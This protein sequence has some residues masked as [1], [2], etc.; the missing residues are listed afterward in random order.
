MNVNSSKRFGR[1][2]LAFLILGLVTLSFSVT[3]EP[4]PPPQSA[5]PIMVPNPATD[6]WRAVRQR[7]G[8]AFGNTQVKGVE[9][10]VL[11]DRTGED[12]RNFRRD[13][14]IGQAGIGI[15][16]VAGLIFL[17]YLKH[18]S[19]KIENGRSGRRIKRFSEYDRIVHWFSAILFVF[20]A[21]TGLILLFG[22]F[23]VLPVF[24]PEVFSVIASACK[25]GHNL[26]GPVYLLSIILLFA[27]Y[28]R[29]NMFEK[30]DARWLAS[31]GGLIGNHHV[32]AGFFNAG[33]KIWFWSAIALGVVV[34]LTGLVLIFP[35]IGFS[36]ELMQLALIVH[37]ITAV[38]FI[39]GSFGH[40]YIGTVGSEGSIDS[41]TT[42]YVDV[43]W[44]T[45]H[46]D[47]WYQEVKHEAVPADPSEPKA[48]S[49]ERMPADRDMQPSPD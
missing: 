4:P 15:A 26:F 46:H 41:M 45:T 17:Y 39:A 34:S 24:G 3:A 36:R 32:H 16:V 9:S 11:I 38:L 10:G 7:E 5:S 23:I 35:I 28:A 27:R 29:K 33:E 30:K 13:D 25:E 31:G 18:G 22:R 37:G 19:I 44:A 21:L 49:R 1:S 48:G 8:P 14:F 40:I 42:G 2:L 43:N 47:D 12:W 6:L 20:M